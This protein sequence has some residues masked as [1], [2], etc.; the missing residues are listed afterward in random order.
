MHTTKTILIILFSGLLCACG[1]DTTSDNLSDYHHAAK[2][3]VIAPQQHYIVKREFTGFVTSSQH[4]EIG[5]E[6]SGKLAQMN[7]DIGSQVQ[8]GELLAKLDTELLNIEQQQLDAQFAE[9][10][11]RLRLNQSS[12]ERQKSLGKSGYSSQQRLDELLAEQDTINAGIARLQASVASIETRIRKSSLLAPFDGTVSAKHV[13]IGTVIAAGTPIIKLLNNT[14]LEARIGVPARLLPGLTPGSAQLLN[15]GQQELG[16]QVIAVGADISSITRTVPVR[17]SLAN[18]STTDNIVDGSLV[19]LLID[20]QIEQAGYWLPLNS[21]TDGMRGLWTIYAAIEEKDDKAPSKE[22]LYR[23]EA[24]AVQIEYT[25]GKE[26]YITADLNNI[27]WIV[28]DGLHRFV[29]GQII[30]SSSL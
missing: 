2:L 23:I 17:L 10:K 6:L 1:Q 9:L 4:G 18:T 7:V 15:I 16:S 21:I 19:K 12:L 24:R 8:A 13:N 14:K 30:R 3:L 29:P 26:V 28:G 11:A 27:Q 25:K 5:F 20:E 22:K